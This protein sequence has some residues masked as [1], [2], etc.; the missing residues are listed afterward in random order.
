MAGR[1]AHFLD[2]HSDVPRFPVKVGNR[3]RDTFAFR[4]GQDDH[5]LSRVTFARNQGRFYD[6][7]VDCGGNLGLA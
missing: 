5:K 7:F 2:N 1:V 3:E 4:I 6:Q